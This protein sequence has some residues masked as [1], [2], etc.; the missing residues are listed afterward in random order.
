MQQESE[1]CGTKHAGLNCWGSAQQ[2]RAAQ[3]HSKLGIQTS[4]RRQVLSMCCR[5][6]KVGLQTQASAA[7]GR[8]NK[9]APLNGEVPKR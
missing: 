6:N 9:E 4:S 3:A 8:C 1:A 2:D 5:W 7:M